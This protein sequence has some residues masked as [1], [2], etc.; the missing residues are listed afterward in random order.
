MM[1]NELKLLHYDASKLIEEHIKDMADLTPEQFLK[2]LDEMTDSINLATKD[3]DKEVMA[4]QSVALNAEQA[5]FDE[6]NTQSQKLGDIQELVVSVLR[7][8]DD[9]S[10]TAVRIGER[11]NATESERKKIEFAEQLLSYVK[12]F[13]EAQSALFINLHT[14]SSAEIKLRLPVR[15]RNEDWGEISKVV[16]LTHF[17]T[18]ELKLYIHYNI[19]T[20]TYYL[21]DCYGSSLNDS[22]ETILIRSL[23]IFTSQIL[24]ILR[25]ILYE[26]RSDDIKSAEVIK[27]TCTYTMLLLL[28]YFCTN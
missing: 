27:T 17:S 10:S 15:L 20:Y 23:H 9:A 28:L 24:H 11:L 6:L 1:R 14:C 7:H 21:Y 12:Y 16:I 3:I 4:A 25:N 2:V 26:I 22:S 13:E 5:M 19:F 18:H 8:F